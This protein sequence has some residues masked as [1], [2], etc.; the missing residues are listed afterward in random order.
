M[1]DS[2]PP[3]AEW[4][5]DNIPAMPLWRGMAAASVASRENEFLYG[6]VN[7]S[8]DRQHRFVMLESANKWEAEQSR[9]ATEKA[10]RFG[11]RAKG[12]AALIGAFGGGSFTG[13]VVT[14]LVEH[15]L[16]A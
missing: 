6:I 1:P 2:F 11:I 14:L 4:S 10:H 9:L 8:L 3:Y 7:P 12:W 15:L 5:T 13:A 16:L